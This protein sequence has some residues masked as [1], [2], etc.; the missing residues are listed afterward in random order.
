[1]R[2]GSPMNTD[3]LDRRLRDAERAIDELRTAQ[4][5]DAAELREALRGVRGD[6]EALNASLREFRVGLDQFWRDRWPMLESRLTRI[7]TTTEAVSQRVAAPG[8][9][10]P[11]PFS[12]SDWRVIAVIAAAIFGGGLTVSGG[13]GTAIHALMSSPS[14]KQAP[15]PNP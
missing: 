15:T 1:M 11:A 2:I 3:D 13:S 12:L 8:I 5:R 14:A 4:G 6:L 7:E 10:A 9:A